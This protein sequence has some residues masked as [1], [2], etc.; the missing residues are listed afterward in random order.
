MEMEGQ[1]NIDFA[2][3]YD[4]TIKALHY[5]AVAAEEL[6]LRRAAERL[7][8]AEPPLS[9]QIRNLEL[10]LGVR[11]F[12]RHSKG[13]EL[14]EE[15]RSA[16]EI[17]Q[18][19][20][21]QYRNAIAR[22]SLLRCDDED[23]IMTVGLTTAF[24]RSALERLQLA[25]RN[26]YGAALHIEWSTS[27]AL[28]RAV[29]RGRLR[30]AFVALPVDLCGLSCR[31]LGWRDDFV[32]ALPAAWPEARKQTLLLKEL[33]HK[34]LFWFKRSLN[35]AFHDFSKKR[36]REIGFTPDIRQEPLEHDVLLA[37]VQAGE[38]AALLPGSF[39]VMGR[40]G[41]VY[42]ELED[43][44]GLGM[45]LGVVAKDGNDALLDKIEAICREAGLF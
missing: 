26:R 4:L 45:E 14:T 27:P 23:A 19:L 32:A 7:F 44:S 41:V 15:G 18:P 1:Q 30:L 33:N 12:E 34:P 2:M 37:R 16:L 40:P 17:L 8:I 43:A 39:T 9:R 3:E 11:L 20:L 25:L 5:F 10:R 38:A 31:P 28:V 36:F 21:A 22:L 42:R 24:E 6:N 35:Q 13:L 29:S